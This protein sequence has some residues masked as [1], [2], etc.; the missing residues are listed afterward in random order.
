MLGSIVWNG[1]SLPYLRKLPKLFR[2]LR[3]S[4]SANT[5]QKGRAGPLNLRPVSWPLRGSALISG[6]GS[7]GQLDFFFAAAHSNDPGAYVG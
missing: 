1:Q 5:L 7:L 6:V 2:G 4:P 3:P